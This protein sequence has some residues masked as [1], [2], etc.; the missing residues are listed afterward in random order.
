M[1]VVLETCRRVWRL[2]DQLDARLMVAPPAARRLTY[3]VTTLVMVTVSLPNVPRMWLDFRHLPL[4]DRVEQRPTYGPDSIADMFTA[5]VVLN[6]PGDMFTKR[7]LD[8]TP[9][10][11]ALWSKEASAPYP[12]VA[13][14]AEA[15]LFALGEHLG[16]GFYGMILGLALL[17]LG[18]SAWYFSQTRWYLFPALY[19]NFF[20]FSER[21][22]YVQDNTYLI[23]L[24][25][26]MAALG[27]AR[28]ARLG[29]PEWPSHLLMALAI[30]VKLSPLYYVVNVV[31]MRPA[32]AVSF[33]A[34]L[35]LGLVMPYFIWE[36]Y[37]YIYRFGSELKGDWNDAIG[38]L[39][40]AGLFAVTIGYV[41]ARLGFDLEDRIGWGLVP[42]AVLLG[43]K[44]NVAR[45]LL[46]VLLVPDKRGLRNAAA[47]VGL[48]VP[49]L[50][51]SVARFNAALPTAVVVLAFGLGAYLDRI[52]WTTVRND[53]RH[54]RQALR[55]ILSRT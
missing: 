19:L 45:H 24:T 15:G 29:R 3:V 32:T 36:N 2:A 54:P 11:A 55:M 26:V 50:L 10:E 52:G 40:V 21:F 9:S 48:A 28:W 46:V 39:V 22:V 34:L 17:F 41:Q 23:L 37:L 14:L 53:L 8:Q 47:A 38:A 18:S 5:R 51:P 13:L 20:Y 49:V 25:V 27:L 16:V 31:R 33:A 12:P 43:L 30:T 4:L 35:L 7:K 42:V 44:M 1:S 6:D